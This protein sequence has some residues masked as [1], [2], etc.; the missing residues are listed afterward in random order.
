MNWT[1]VGH[2]YCLSSLK[3]S[4]CSL[5]LIVAIA[6]LVRSLSYNVMLLTE[7]IFLILETTKRLGDLRLNLLAQCVEYDYENGP[8]P[9]KIATCVLKLNAQLALINPHWGLMPP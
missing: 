2:L 5:G 1:L 3:D 8:D 4:S 6:S 9:T 7:I